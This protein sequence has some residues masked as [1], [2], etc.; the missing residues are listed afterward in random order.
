M[1]LMNSVL[2]IY[3]DKFVI[4]FI[5][6]ILVY[7][8]NEEDHV[9]HLAALLRSLRENLFYAKINKCS[10]FHTEVHYLG[11][12]VFKDGMAVDLEKVRVIME[13]AAPRN[14]DEVRYFMV[15]VCYYRRFIRNFL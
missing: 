5:N 14:V 15:L 6:E 7:S 12:V 2:H 10:F 1:F 8:K 4:V 9:D 3:L 11:Y 13:W